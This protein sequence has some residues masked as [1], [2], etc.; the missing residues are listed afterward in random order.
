VC[1]EKKKHG[2]FFAACLVLVLGHPGYCPASGHVL[3]DGRIIVSPLPPDYHF[4]PDGSVN[5]RVCYNWSCASTKELVFSREDLSAVTREM[6]RCSGKALHERLQ[7]IRIGVWKMENLARKYL[8]VLANDRAVNDQ[9]RD[10]EG[11]TD[12]VDNASNTTTFLRILDELSV[13]DGWTASNPRV[14]D[15]FNLWQVH[16]T[17][18]VID[19]RNGDHWA[20][21]SWFRPHGHLPFVMPLSG[22]LAGKK[23]WKAPFDKSNPYPRYVSELCEGGR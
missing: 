3:I 9:D 23:G 22:W 1:S 17:A 18:V 11:R 21:D 8:P 16:W 12:C 10:S 7:S 13:L 4:N 19:D 2:V 20:V 15:R 6:M 14:R 5:L